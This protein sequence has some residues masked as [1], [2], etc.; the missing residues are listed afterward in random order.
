MCE[1]S[2]VLDLCLQLQD[3]APNVGKGVVNHQPANSMHVMQCA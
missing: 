1:F 2:N 3:A